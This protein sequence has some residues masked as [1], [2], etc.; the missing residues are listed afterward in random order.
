[1]G[2]TYDFQGGTLPKA[3]ADFNKCKH[4]DIIMAHILVALS[5][6]GYALNIRVMPWNVE[7][8]SKDHLYNLR[9]S[10]IYLWW[11][12]SYD[13]EGN[14]SVDL[15]AKAK[16][17]LEQ[18]LATAR[19]AVIPRRPTRQQNATMGPARPPAPAT[20][21]ATATATV[22]TA[23]RGGARGIYVLVLFVFHSVYFIISII[24][25]V[26]NSN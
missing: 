3:I 22:T 17:W 26:S 9:Y 19:T 21:P 6:V 13:D 8:G 20:A 1:V 11:Q 2:S 18:I 4:I 7:A 15:L 16:V 10:D 23:S 25:Y 14:F 24:V 12:R 5:R